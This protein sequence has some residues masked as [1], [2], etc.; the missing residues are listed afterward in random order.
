MSNVHVI[1]VNDV[2]GDLIDILYA[3]HACV[4]FDST[5]S[6]AAWPAPEA[7][8]YPVYCHKCGGRVAEVPL[9]E[10]GQAEYGPLLNVVITGDDPKEAAL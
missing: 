5:G 6:W 10:A 2:H 7:V 3:H 8:D 9:T 4:W 1:H